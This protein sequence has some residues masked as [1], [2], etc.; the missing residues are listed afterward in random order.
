MTTNRELV[1]KSL[2]PSLTLLAEAA[3]SSP[4]FRRATLL[5]LFRSA[6]LMALMASAGT[7][8]VGS[9][10]GSAQ[11]LCCAEG[12]LGPSS[13]NCNVIMIADDQ[14][15]GCPGGDSVNVFTPGHPKWLRIRI[16]YEDNDCNFKVG[17][18]PESIWVTHKITQGNLKLNDKGAKVFA[19]DYTDVFG[20]T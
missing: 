8:L 18:P 7:L 3:A 1:Q 6:M 15:T 16:H 11:S 2:R 13:Q 5:P 12:P 10:T 4:Q 9:R 19:D 20:D 17:V 14:I